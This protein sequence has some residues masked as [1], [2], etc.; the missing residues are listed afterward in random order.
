MTQGVAVIRADDGRGTR[1]KLELAP[2]LCVE[3]ND[4]LET[5]WQVSDIESLTP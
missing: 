2:T 1:D 5:Y 3:A 4:V